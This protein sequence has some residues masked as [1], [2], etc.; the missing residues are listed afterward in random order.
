M[1]VTLRPYRSGGW[2]VDITIRLPNGKQYR[3]RKRAARFSK[4]AALRW[5]Q[6][7]ERF[8]LQH[9]PPTNQKEV[10]TLETFAPR[11]VDG[12]ARANRHKPSGIAA[13]GSILRLHLIPT[14]GPKRLDAI[15]NEQ[16]QRLKLALADRAPKTVNNVLTVLSTLLKKAVE[17]GELERL[18]CAIKV[19]PNPRKTMGFHDFDQYER[20]LAVARKR[21]AQAYLMTL[22][23]G[24]AGLRLG[25]IVALEWRDVDLGARR[26]SVERSDWL[27]HVGV[28]KGGRSRQLPMTQR[29]TAALKASRHLRSE[30]VLCLPDGAPITRDRVIKAIRGAQRVAGITQGVHILRHTFCSH[31]AMKGAPARAIQEVAGHADLS[32]TQRYMHLSPAATEDAIRLLDE[33]QTGLDR[34][35]TFGDILDTRGADLVTVREGRI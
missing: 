11:F 21:D 13:I 3:E 26:L 24:D 14:L 18:S 29:L 5:A 6:E 1:S 33:R 23:G 27:G 30:R 28:P 2:E 25:E 32:T 35:E 4:T 19:L 7:R 12:H 10:P 8:L 15:T 34:A 31:L 16:V 17:W 22:L 20:L 9:G